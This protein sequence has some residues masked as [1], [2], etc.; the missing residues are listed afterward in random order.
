MIPGS[1]GGGTGIPTIG[2]CCSGIGT[3]GNPGGASGGPGF[4]MNAAYP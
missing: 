4:G 3:C 1:I 2:G